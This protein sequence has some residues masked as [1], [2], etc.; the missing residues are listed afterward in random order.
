MEWIDTLNQIGLTG[1][2][3]TIA[4]FLIYRYF[5]KKDNKEV[6]E[7][8][9]TNELSVIKEELNKL[10]NELIKVTNDYDEEISKIHLLID[11]LLEAEQALLREK[12]IKI[13]NHY[14]N[15]KHYFPIYARESLEH[16][17]NSYKKMGGNGVIDDLVADLNSLPTEIV[18]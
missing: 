5:K 7:D 10:N 14:Y 16:M 2:I 15:E 8:N 12:I 1:F 3:F 17:Y 4:S 18:D 11:S 6:K 13:Y 9:T